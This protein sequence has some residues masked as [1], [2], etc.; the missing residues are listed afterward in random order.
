MQLPLAPDAVALQTEAAKEREE[1][2]A[3]RLWE[4]DEAT[5]RSLRMALREIA[6]K[7][8]CTRQWKEFWEPVDPEEDPQYYAQVCAV[9]IAPITSS[10]DF[11]IGLHAW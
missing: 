7:L 1:A 8:L 10:V 11:G 2:E 3:R 4:E 6:T 9:T 5:L